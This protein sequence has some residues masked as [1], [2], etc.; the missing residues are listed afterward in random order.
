LY[1]LS[2]KV[3]VALLCTRAKM[4]ISNCDKCGY[5]IGYVIKNYGLFL[6]KGCIC[7][8]PNTKR[9][10]PKLSWELVKFVNDNPSVAEAFLA[11]VKKDEKT[12]KP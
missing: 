9:L 11:K 8:S 2:S 6:D 5:E 12:K 4:V 1:A 7:I 3:H 10:E